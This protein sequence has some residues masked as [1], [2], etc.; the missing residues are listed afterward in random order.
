MKVN[1]KYLFFWKNFRYMG[2]V[3]EITNN[4]F[5][6]DDYK[7]GVIFIPIN[8]TLVKEVKE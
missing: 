4:H 1:K 6:V 7:E 8:D 3:I 2:K 5:V